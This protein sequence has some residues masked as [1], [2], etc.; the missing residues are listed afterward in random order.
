MCEIRINRRSQMAVVQPSKFRRASA[1]AN[2]TY[3]RASVPAHLHPL[4][5]RAGT[6]ARPYKRGRLRWASVSLAAS[7]TALSMLRG[8]YGAGKGVVV[9]KITRGSAQFQVNGPLTTIRAADR[10][11]INYR[12]FSID[13]GQTVQFIQP[14]THARVLNRI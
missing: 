4:Q 14:G 6:E 7:L 5:A 11:I 13:A 2:G 1:Q 8:A 12:I 9:D 3:G 10:T